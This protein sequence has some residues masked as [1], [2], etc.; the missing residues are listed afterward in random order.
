MFYTAV[1][2]VWPPLQDRVF[3]LPDKNHMDALLFF[4]LALGFLL[5]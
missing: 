5:T 2:A 1:P 3:N 4:Y